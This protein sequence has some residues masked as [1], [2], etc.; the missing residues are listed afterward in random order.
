VGGD[1]WFPKKVRYR[2]VQDGQE[3]I[4][5]DL[6]VELV[7]MNRPLEE[8]WFGPETMDVPPGTLVSSIPHDPAAPLKWDGAR[9]VGMNEFERADLLYGHPRE[10]HGAHRRLFTAISAAFGLAAVALVVLR[11]Y[12]Q[13]ASKRDGGA[14]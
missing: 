3:T 4:G 10:T 14:G 11:R 8:K 2:R 7:S 12:R 9:V 5:Q 6:D 1:A 13:R